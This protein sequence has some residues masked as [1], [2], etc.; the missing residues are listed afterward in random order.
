MAVVSSYVVCVG[1][2]LGGVVVGGAGRKGVKAPYDTLEVLRYV[3][4]VGI[5]HE[6]SSSSFYVVEMSGSIPTTRESPVLSF[7]LVTSSVQSYVL[8]HT[9]IYS[10]KFIYLGKPNPSWT[11]QCMKFQYEPV[12]K[13]IST[14]PAR[15][16]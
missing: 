14:V 13:N 7:V 12:G 15:R 5:A 3:Y 9:N 2:L 6:V 10:Y 8:F 11:E 16:I 1:V 4:G